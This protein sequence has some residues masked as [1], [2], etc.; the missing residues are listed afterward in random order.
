MVLPFQNNRFVHIRILTL[1]CCL[2]MASPASATVVR[3]NSNLGSFD[4]RMFNTSTPLSV[5]NILNYVNDGDFDDSIVHRVENTISQ[6]ADGTFVNDP[7][8]IQGG[9]WSLPPASVLTQIPS[10][11]PV[12]NEPGISNLRGT[13]ALARVGGQINSGTNN[14]FV[15]TRDNAFLDTIDQGFTV[16]GRVVHDGMQVVD[17]IANLPKQT[18]F[19]QFGQSLGNTFPMHGD[20]SSGITRD[21]FVLFSSVTDLNIPDGDYDFDGDVDGSDFLIWQRGNNSTTDVAADN[22]GDAIVD[23]ADLVPWVTNYGTVA[24]SAAQS[25]PEP[26]TQV[27]LSFTLLALSFVARPSRRDY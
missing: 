1:I 12:L 26:S 9:D 20:F 7:F 2:T 21:N 27:I 25:V 23:A 13:F 3:F 8:V 16:F 19:N 11:P 14:W 10:D 6:L 18:I 24:L 4:V 5:A 22:N 15:N 17:S